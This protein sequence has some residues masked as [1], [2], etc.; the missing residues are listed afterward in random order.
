MFE[1]N[2]DSGKSTPSNNGKK[3]KSRPKPR[4]HVGAGQVRVA[5][6]QG[7]LVSLSLV[8][9]LGEMAF[10]CVTDNGDSCCR[11]SVTVFHQFEHAFFSELRMH[12][13]TVGV[14]ESTK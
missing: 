9:I 13:I 7:R 8:R 3:G 1:L 4:E 6:S 11:L 10:V 2:S 14:L 5:T 12:L